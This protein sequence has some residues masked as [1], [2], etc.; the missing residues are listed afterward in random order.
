[1]AAQ[2][3]NLQAARPPHDSRH[4]GDSAGH[5]GA[6]GAVL[7]AGAA[8]PRHARR[9][10]GAALHGGVAG[11]HERLAVL[12]A[13][14]SDRLLPGAHAA[15]HALLRAD[16]D[17]GVASLHSERLEGRPDGPHAAKVQD[18]GGEDAD[19]GGDPVRGVMAAVVLHFRTHQ[20]G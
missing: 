2:A 5:H 20:V 17:Q 18:Q 1:M 15:D 4:L 14:Q 10:R 6:V 3:A 16:L 12:S 19:R 8:V 9:P 7:Q 11:R 13:R